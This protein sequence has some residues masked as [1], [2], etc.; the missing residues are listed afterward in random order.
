MKK[1]FA[2]IEMLVGVFILVTVGLAVAGAFISAIKSVAY[3]K[4][5]IAATALANEKMETIHNLPYNDLGTTNGTITLPIPVVISIPDNETVI[6]EG[7]TFNVQT[8]INYYND[9]FDDIVAQN[10]PDTAPYDYKKVSIS[11]GLIGKPALTTLA[12]IIGAKAAETPTD[13]GILEICVIDSSGAPVGLASITVT[14]SSIT[15][16]FNR[17]GFTDVNTGCVNFYELPPNKNKP[18]RYHVVATKGD[19]TY[20]SD[21]TYDG[22]GSQN[23]HSLQSDQ[24]VFIQQVT[25]LILTIDLLSSLEVEFKDTAG[26]PIPD[27]A[28]TLSGSKLIHDNP[29]TPKYTPTPW[30]TG[31]DGKITIPN[32][33]FDNYSITNISGSYHL[34]SASP[35]DINNPDYP[36]LLPA[37]TT[38]LLVTATLSH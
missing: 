11:V 32:L 9:P 17:T 24:D 4:T 15:P 30:T 22:P 35:T 8:I 28:F 7:I 38:P 1:G 16:P 6:K 20:S 3:T 10:P 25:S 36:I 2:L 37:G 13:T 31:V 14:N 26:T 34:V 19:N 33:E 18:K 12:T 5:V 23:P 21:Y 27:I 29:D